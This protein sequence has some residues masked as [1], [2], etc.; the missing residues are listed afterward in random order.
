MSQTHVLKPLQGLW[1]SKPHKD[2]LQPVASMTAKELGA[3]GETIACSYL[4]RN[5]YRIIDRN[6]SCRYG[7]LDIVALAPPTVTQPR[8]RLIIAEVKTRRSMLFGTPMEAIT[9]QKLKRMR[10]AS[11]LWRDAHPAEGKRQTRFDAIAIDFEDSLKPTISHV[12][13][14]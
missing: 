14:I 10:R 6:W 11:F 7:E 13:G 12:K 8:R 1:E 4:E 2:C 3:Y 5:G 9:P